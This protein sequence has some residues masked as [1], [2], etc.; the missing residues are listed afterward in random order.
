M[1][2]LSQLAIEKECR[3]G[4]IIAL[5]DLYVLSKFA[6]SDEISTICFPSLELATSMLQNICNIFESV[7]LT[8]DDKLKKL[9]TAE[10]PKAD[11]NVPAEDPEAPKA[12]DN[13]PAVSRTLFIH[14]TNLF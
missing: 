7:I 13:V 5:E 6:Q 14:F 10:A 4:S 2:F 9:V 11:D 1:K 3:I 8:G 12:D